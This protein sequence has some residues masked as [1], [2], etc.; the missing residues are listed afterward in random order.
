MKMQTVQYPGEV[1]I[2]AYAVFSCNNNNNNNN[3]TATIVVTN[4]P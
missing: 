2:L 3:M 4:R 1:K